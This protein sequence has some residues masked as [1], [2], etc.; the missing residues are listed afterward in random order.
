MSQIRAQHLEALKR[1]LLQHVGRDVQ[2]VEAPAAIVDWAVAKRN[3]AAMLEAVDALG[4]GFRAH[5]KTHKVSSESKE[6]RAHGVGLVRGMYVVS[7][8]TLIF[9]TS[10]RRLNLL[11]CKWVTIQKEPI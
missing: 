7:R 4:L 8:I 10:T 5:V 3:C 6:A 2:D 9:V 1:R 11:E